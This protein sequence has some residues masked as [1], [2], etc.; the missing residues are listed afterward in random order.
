MKIMEFSDWE[1]Q[2]MATEKAKERGKNYICIMPT[3]GESALL[4]L[5]KALDTVN[6]AGLDGKKLSD[7]KLI[8]RFEPSP[9]NTFYEIHA[10]VTHRL[11]A[12][13]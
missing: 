11:K 6:Q 13:T 4:I 10:K 7:I 9:E 8:T 3:P 5:M 2:H 12:T 1:M